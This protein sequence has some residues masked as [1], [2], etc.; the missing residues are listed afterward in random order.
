[1]VS[2]KDYNMESNVKVVAATLINEVLTK[3]KIHIPEELFDGFVESV[4][5]RASTA[6]TEYGELFVEKEGDPA[7]FDADSVY[8]SLGQLAILAVAS[9]EL[10]LICKRQLEDK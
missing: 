4:I 8:S 10:L 3:T 1:M 5:E 7:Y 2:M 9:F 6:T